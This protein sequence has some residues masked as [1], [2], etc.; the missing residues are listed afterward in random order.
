MSTTASPPAGGPRGDGQVPELAHGTTDPPDISEVVD[1]LGFGFAQVQAVI[2]GG[3][4][5]L[6]DG[7]ELLLIGSV[8]HTIADDWSLNPWERGAI[9]SIVFVGVLIGNCVGGMLGDFF[10][11]RS[12]VLASYFMVASCSILS[13]LTWG[14]WSLAGAQFLVGISFGFGQPAWNAMASEVSPTEWRM[15]VASA[16]MMMFVFGEVYSAFLVWCDDPHMRDLDWRWLLAMGAVPSVILFILAFFRLQES[17]PFLAQIGQHQKAHET[18]EEMRRNNACPEVDITYRIAG[19]SAGTRAMQSSASRDEES[20]VS[21]VSDS[22]KKQLNIVFARHLLFSTIV[23]CFMCFNLNLV[24]YGGLYA[25]PQVFPAVNSYTSPAIAILW[26]ALAELPGFLLGGVC[27]VVMGRKPAMLC[28]HAV[29]A[30]CLAIFGFTISPRGMALSLEIYRDI[31]FAGLKMF[32]AIGNVVVY[33]YSTEIFPTSARMTGTAICVAAGRLGS[34]AC[35]FLFEALLQLTGGFEAFF[36]VSASCCTASALL[37]VLLPLET[38]KMR[39]DDEFLEGGEPLAPGA[40][41]KL[42]VKC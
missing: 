22:L 41:K 17:P 26:G 12:P 1:R 13:A 19:S 7:A 31:S 15:P 30:L 5:W 33:Q 14:F 40:G 25:F 6:A 9:V 35:P 2:L 34:M 38:S 21:N 36:Y 29:M 39:L 28:I 10:G 20:T 37:S 32:T 16:S 3:A 18:L 8:T 42:A 24:Y 11:R 23:V 4:V 27:G